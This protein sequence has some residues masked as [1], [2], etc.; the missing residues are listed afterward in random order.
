MGK[1]GQGEEFGGVIG[2]SEI[3]ISLNFLIFGME[4]WNLDRIEI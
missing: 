1:R 2:N 3:L 4:F